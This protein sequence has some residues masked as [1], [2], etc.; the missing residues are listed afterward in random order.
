MASYREAQDLINIGAYQ[1]GSNPNIDRAI[2][3]QPKINQLLKQGTNEFPSQEE[4]FE[5]MNAVVG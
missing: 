3:A 5:L 2:K 4:T 1:Q